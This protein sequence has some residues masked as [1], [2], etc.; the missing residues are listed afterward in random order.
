MTRVTR[1][2]EPFLSHILELDTLK[3]FLNILMSFPYYWVGQKIFSSF[4]HKNKIFGQSSSPE[5]NHT[6][7]NLPDS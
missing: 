6:H 4:S 7:R 5:K 1:E 2:R 3:T